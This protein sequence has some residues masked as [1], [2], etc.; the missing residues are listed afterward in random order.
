M[1]LT[2]RYNKQ[3]AGVISCYDRIIIQGTLPGWCFDQGM[4]SFLNANG[5]KIFDYPKFAQT[6]REEIRNNAECIAEANG[7]EI[8]FIRKTKEFRKEK[9][10]KEILKERGEH[11]GL[12]HIFSAM[13][14][15]TSYKP[16]HDKKSGKTFLTI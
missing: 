11:P 5:I 9:R 8:E 12:V 2:E 6:L 10:I 7:L 15:C 4:T 3:I 16:W 1:L 14:S 13:E